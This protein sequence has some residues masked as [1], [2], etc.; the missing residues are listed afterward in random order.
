MNSSTMLSS[1]SAVRGRLTTRSMLAPAILI[2]IAA[3]LA[4]RCPI[5][6]RAA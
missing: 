6:R 1:P 3:L 2:G 5:L 4:G